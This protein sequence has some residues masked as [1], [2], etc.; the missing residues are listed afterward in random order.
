MTVENTTN[1]SSNIPVV[2]GTAA[3]KRYA[4][5]EAQLE[6]WLSSK[7]STEAN[8][9]YNEITTLKLRGPLN[10]K[11]LVTALTQVTQRHQCLNAAISKDGLE[12]IV[13]S[14]QP[15]DIRQVDFSHLSEEDREIERLKAIQQ[16]GCTPFDLENGPLFRTVLQKY[17]ETEHHL[18]VTAHHLVLDGW[19][20]NVLSRDLGVLYDNENGKPGQLPP[21]NTYQQ[22]SRAMDQYFASDDAAADEA[23][24]VDQYSDHVPVLDLPI[25]L[26]RPNERT[27]FARR[28]DHVLD[29]ELVEQL[30]QMGAKSGC[31]IFNTLLAAF[32]CFVARI[33]GC[34]DF[35]IGIATAG[36]M[37][38]EQPE[39][40]GNCVNTMPFRSK[41]DTRNR[42]TDHLNATRSNLLDSF[43]HQRFSF[44]KLLSKINFKRDPRRAPMLAIS[45]NI[46]PAAD[47]TKVGFTGLEVEVAVEPR[48][49]ENFEW[50]ING[51]IC[52]DKSIELQ[53]QYNSDLFT[54]S[55][56]SFL[57]EGFAGFLEQLASDPQQVV[58]NVPVMSL[59]QRQKVLVDWNRTDREYSTTRTLHGLISEQAQRTPSRVAIEFADRKLTYRE[60]DQQSNQWARWLRDL[61][62]CSGAL[63][64]L[65]VDRS[66]QMVV[67]LLGILKSGA[68]YVPLDPAFPDERLKYMCDQSQLQLIVAGA[69]NREQ[70]APFE[71]PMKI[72]EDSLS[73]IEA[74]SKDAFEVDVQQQDTCYVIYT[75]GSTGDPKGVNVPHGVVANFLHSMAETPGFGSNDKVLAVT[76][77]SFDIAV[78]EL[79][80]PLLT[81]GTCVI[82]S[83]EMVRDGNSLAAAIEDNGI[84]LFQSTPSTLRLMISAQWNGV[85][86][87][88]ILCGGEPMPSDLVGPLLK[89]C[90]ELWNMYGPTETTVWSSIYQ[91]TEADEPILIGKPIANTQI[92]LLDA[93]MQPVP[94]GSDGEVFIGG[95]GVTLGYLHRDDLTDQ[96]FVSN[97][98]FN[99]FVDWCSNKIYKTGDLARYRHDGNIEFLRRN[100]KQVK[101]RGFR[102]E[103]GEI[104][105]RLKDVTGVS[106]AVAIVREDTPG[107]SR[108]VG[109][110][111]DDPAKPQS[112][113]SVREQLKERLPYYMVPQFLVPLESMPQTNNGKIDYK[114]LPAP[115]ALVP[116]EEPAND[117]PE[118]AAQKL[119]VSIWSTILKVDDIQPGDNFFDLGGHSL[120]VM[121]A[122]S[123]IEKQ[124][125]ARLSPPDFLAGSLE[126]LADKVD[127]TASLKPSAVEVSKTA[128]APVAV[129][130]PPKK[131]QP[132]TSEP[133]KK[134]GP[135][136]KGI[137]KSIKGFWD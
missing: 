64:G 81:G 3:S 108:L 122:I 129:D 44:G 70:V 58:A 26:K 123:E 117:A 56:M 4:T 126:Q 66:E 97:P 100:D 96:R 85:K 60:L 102:I 68:G 22:Y 133:N 23:F 67:A 72:I 45:F 29:A 65:C 27:Y 42:F 16:E 119:M 7:Q 86:N 114:A 19:S 8:C 53:V 63:V 103:L 101:V 74:Q 14:A 57:F 47:T 124:T 121:Q 38:M 127:E 54:S 77:L 94:V 10:V 52:A 111:V 28:Y 90:G 116:R 98:W 5:T 12:L 132:A 55:A 17:S 31:S 25:D 24:W 39:L 120:L 50:S 109:Y 75:S 83:Q 34:D 95:A 76:T 46:D 112:V 88:K 71:K 92:Y 135:A 134:S 131:D 82:A 2:V 79:Y 37:A 15:L 91:I 18:T 13:N 84:T 41:V 128:P 80:L 107:D 113:E 30:G 59:A 49:F 1:T 62:V 11:A 61:G 93:N 32:E 36:Q 6:L 99:P 48:M 105:T 35:C 73:E 125:G 33:S 69:E 78:L 106:E 89:R 110:W 21:A 9:A 115:A 43:E 137:F 40:I 87:L 136:N 51:V 20:L 118:T 130:V 104:E